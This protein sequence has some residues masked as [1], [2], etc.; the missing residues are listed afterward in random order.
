MNLPGS[1]ENQYIMKAVMQSFLTLQE[2]IIPFL[3]EL[4]PKLTEKL[5]IVG[6]NPSRP[7]FNHYLFETL[8]ISIRIGCVADSNAVTSFEEVLFPIFHGILQQNIQDIDLYSF[9]FYIVY[10]EWTHRTTA[11]AS[12]M[13]AQQIR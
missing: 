1:H 4:L 10:I 11:L 3:V 2:Y 12:Y 9:I 13:S 8:S 5:S 6:K 7:H